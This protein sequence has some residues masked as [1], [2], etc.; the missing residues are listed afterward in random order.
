VT[1]TTAE[2]MQKVREMMHDRQK[3]MYKDRG[4][5]S[6]NAMYYGAGSVSW[7]GVRG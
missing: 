7:F 6:K 5:K 1:P 3:K 4:E 2:E